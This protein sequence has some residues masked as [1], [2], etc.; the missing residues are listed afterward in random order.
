MYHLS[1]N[2]TCSLSADISYPCCS[3]KEEDFR[4]VIHKLPINSKVVARFQ[5]HTT[6]S[7]LFLFWITSNGMYIIQHGIVL[8]FATSD[9]SY[10]FVLFSWP[11]WVSGFETQ[12]EHIWKSAMPVNKGFCS[13]WNIA[14]SKSPCFSFIFNGS[15][16][17]SLFLFPS[18]LETYLCL[19][20]LNEN[21]VSMKIVLLISLPP[22][23]TTSLPTF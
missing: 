14:F 13:N 17:L 11:L 15:L 1:A 19:F 2:L 8:A 20:I 7:F 16:S 6:M 3:E 4:C 18:S 9:L 21:S 12:K 5:F 23:P 10:L 22:T